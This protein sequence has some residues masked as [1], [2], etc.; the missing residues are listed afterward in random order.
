M[1]PG[2]PPPASPGH[3]SDGRPVAGRRVGEGAGVLRTAECAFGLGR[4]V[5]GRVLCGVGRRRG[6]GLGLADCPPRGVGWGRVVGP[7]RA[8]AAAVA[9]TSS[10]TVRAA[11]VGDGAAGCL[12]ATPAPLAAGEPAAANRSAAGSRPGV[13]PVADASGAA[14]GDLSGRGDAAG[15]V[16]PGSEMWRTTDAAT[17]TTATTITAQRVCATRVR[18]FA[19]M[20]ESSVNT[21]PRPRPTTTVSHRELYGPI[22]RNPATMYRLPRVGSCPEKVRTRSGNAERSTWW[23][24]VSPRPLEFHIALETLQGLVKARRTVLA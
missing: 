10:A 23:S 24:C 13:E 4:V 12:V 18:I 8:T 9:T 3:R 7:G 14:A 20:P 22:R 19:R 21:G 1:R 17:A 5:G 15:G 11:G 6:L 2:V 16:N